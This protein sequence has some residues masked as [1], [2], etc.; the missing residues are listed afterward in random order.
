MGE[1]QPEGRF[2]SKTLHVLWKNLTCVG[3]SSPIFT[4]QNKDNMAE[5]IISIKNVVK[6]Y[7]NYLAVNDVSFDV[8]TGSMFGLLG[9]NGAG[10]TSLIR[11]ITTITG[12]DSGQILLDGQRL[13]QDS[14]RHIGYMPEERGLYKK[15]KVGEHLIYLARLKDLSERDARASI[16]EWLTKFEIKDWWNKKI[17]DLSKGMQQKIQFIAT[18]V[19]RPKLLILDEPFTGLDPIN[20]NLIKDEIRELHRNGTSIIFSTHRMEQVEE[21]CEHIVLINKGRN[22][23]YGPVRD[24]QERYKEHLFEV[25]F[26]GGL[27]VGFL[28]KQEIVRRDEHSFVAKLA[29]GADSN[30]LVRELIAAGVRLRSFREIMPTFNEIFI[31]TVGENNHE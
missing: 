14:P 23:L 16:D 1:L 21:M 15:M 29:P 4:H 17:E 12:P 3:E 10:K 26:L 24:I 25:E 18:V 30:Q 5:N 19:H 31:K 6:E 28:E 13:S 2:S 11:M 22:V 8:P 7:G 20:T 9:P 27:P